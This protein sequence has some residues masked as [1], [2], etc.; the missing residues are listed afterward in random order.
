MLKSLILRFGPNGISDRL[1]ITTGAMTV[2][3]GPN[4]AGKSLLLREISACCRRGLS[5][6][7]LTLEDI[8]LALP[9][10]DEIE[11]LLRTRAP[12]FTSAS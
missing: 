10:P 3:V 7:D 6:E 8:E 5:S 2:F 4:N 12:C 1:S 11:P 9:K